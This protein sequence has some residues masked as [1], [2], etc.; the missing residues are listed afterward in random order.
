MILKEVK[1]LP[2]I[3]QLAGNRA[4]PRIRDRLILETT[5]SHCTALPPCFHS[6][7]PCLKPHVL[8][9]GILLNNDQ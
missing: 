5:L 6:Q 1:K 8:G 7:R 3:T 2:E 9:K 4:R